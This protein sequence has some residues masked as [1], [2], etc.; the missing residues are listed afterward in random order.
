MKPKCVHMR[1]VSEAAKHVSSTKTAMNRKKNY[2]H[3]ACTVCAQDNLGY[4]R[5]SLE[6]EESYTKMSGQESQLGVLHIT[7][8]NDEN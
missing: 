5:A 3:T 8:E 7:L 4:I 1:N 2:E 6:V